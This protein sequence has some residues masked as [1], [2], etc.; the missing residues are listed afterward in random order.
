MVNPGWMLHRHSGVGDYAAGWFF[1]WKEH[2]RCVVRWPVLRRQEGG[3]NALHDCHS[4]F[5]FS[6]SPGIVVPFDFHLHRNTYRWKWFIQHFSLHVTIMLSE[7]GLHSALSDVDADCLA[8][9]RRIAC[10]RLRSPI[11][12]RKCKNKCRRAKVSDL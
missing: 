1:S 5:S 11:R 8:A 7:D 2:S 9:K 6:A 3:G 4:P 12:Y 10:V